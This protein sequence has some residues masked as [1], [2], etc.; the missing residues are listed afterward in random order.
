M[1]AFVNLVCLI[2]LCWFAWDWIKAKINKKKSEKA[3]QEVNNPT[4]TVNQDSDNS[5]N[6]SLQA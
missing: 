1:T 6:L 2:I 5:D 4:A 3:E